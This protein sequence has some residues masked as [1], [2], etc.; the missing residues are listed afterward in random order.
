MSA[1]QYTILAFE[2][3]LTRDREWFANH[4]AENEYER[5]VMQG[6]I[7]IPKKLRRLLRKLGFAWELRG[8]VTVRRIGP[9]LRSRH[10]DRVYVATGG[11]LEA[12][13]ALA[14]AGFSIFPTDGE[15]LGRL[16]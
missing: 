9:G 2:E 13:I 11:G 1:I 5:P 6:E 8:Q 14:K 3:A 10:F 16:Q 7:D 15:P 4:P 12:A